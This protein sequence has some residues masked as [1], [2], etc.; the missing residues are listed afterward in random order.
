[1][2]SSVRGSFCP[3]V[4]AVGGDFLDAELAKELAAAGEFGIDALQDAQAEF[5]VGFDGD[6]A[7][8]GQARCVA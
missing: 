5:A 1:M 3:V 8:V 4:C 7:G 2:S 6:G